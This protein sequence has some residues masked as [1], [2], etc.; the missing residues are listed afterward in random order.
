MKKFIENPQNC[1]KNF[2]LLQM[3]GQT[4]RPSYEHSLLYRC[5][6]ASKNVVLN[7]FFYGLFTV[8]VVWSE[9]MI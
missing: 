9:N 7:S 5:E 8:N 1:V 3:D 4:D 2:F 6:D